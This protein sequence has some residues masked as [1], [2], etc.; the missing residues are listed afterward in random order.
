MESKD[1]VGLVGKALLCIRSKRCSRAVCAVISPYATLRER[2]AKR[3]L[4]VGQPSSGLAAIDA[5]ITF[6]SITALRMYVLLCNVPEEG[7]VEVRRQ[8]ER[9]VPIQSASVDEGLL[10]TCNGRNVGNFPAPR[11]KLIRT[12]TKR[13]RRRYQAEECGRV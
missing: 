13:Q 11:V 10:A 2:N 8:G 7:Q 3:S 9:H 4:A 12:Q 1:N 6:Q 5:S